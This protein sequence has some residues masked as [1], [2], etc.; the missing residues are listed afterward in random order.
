MDY[1]NHYIAKRE[2]TEGKRIGITHIAI[3]YSIRTPTA[4]NG[5]NN[6]KKITILAIISFSTAYLMA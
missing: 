3:I 6:T 2:K 5:K 4:S 1:T